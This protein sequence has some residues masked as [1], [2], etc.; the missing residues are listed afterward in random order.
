MTVIAQDFKGRRLSLLARIA[1]I[2]NGTRY[3]TRNSVAKVI[4]GEAR[5]T[6]PAYANS[7]APHGWPAKA[8]HSR[9]KIGCHVW[10]GDEARKITDWALAR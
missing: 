10:S 2:T 6:K 8:S 1:R 7:Q 3:V 5:Y 4:R 9:V